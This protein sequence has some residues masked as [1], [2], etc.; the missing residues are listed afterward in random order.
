MKQWTHSLR[1]PNSSQFLIATQVVDSNV[2]SWNNVCTYPLGRISVS[3][4]VSKLQLRVYR[5]ET[6]EVEGEK[7]RLLILNVNPNQV[8]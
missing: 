2:E 6:D 1:T 7:A 3:L 4:P 5:T 8:K